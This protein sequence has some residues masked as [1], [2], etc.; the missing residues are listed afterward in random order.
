MLSR[1]GMVEVYTDP[2]LARLFA[3][4]ARDGAKVADALGIYCETT[5]RSKCIP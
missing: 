2:G 1:L 5:P 4:M 3:M